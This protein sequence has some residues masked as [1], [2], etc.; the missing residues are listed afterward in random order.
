MTIIRATDL[1]REEVRRLPIRD[2]R[3]Q[4]LRDRRDPGW[5][6]KR[7]RVRY[8]KVLVLAWALRAWDGVELPSRV[9][10]LAVRLTS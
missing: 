2:L 1:T 8:L 5:E 7:H 4:I 9:R 6:E 10:R 3:R